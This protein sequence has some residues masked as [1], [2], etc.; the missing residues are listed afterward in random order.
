MKTELLVIF[1]G[2]IDIFHSLHSD[3][4]NLKFIRYKFTKTN[5]LRIKPTKK[6]FTESSTGNSIYYC[7]F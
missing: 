3:E 6:W 5:R 2:T 7:V 4:L 1:L